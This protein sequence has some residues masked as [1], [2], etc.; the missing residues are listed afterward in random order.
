MLLDQRLRLVVERRFPRPRSLD[1]LA[2]SYQVGPPTEHGHAV[3]A[4]SA[5]CAHPLPNAEAILRAAAT[6]WAVYHAMCPGADRLISF[7]QLPKRVVTAYGP[8]GHGIDVQGAIALGYATRAGICMKTDAGRA[9]AAS[10]AEAC[11]ILSRDEHAAMSSHGMREESPSAETNAA[12]PRLTKR[13]CANGW[14][15]R[16]IVSGI[17]MADV[18]CHLS[19]TKGVC[20]LIRVTGGSSSVIPPACWPGVGWWRRRPPSGV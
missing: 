2:E 12:G 4:N 15:T 6:T 20:R 14:G 13:T 10:E 11:A 9:I 19:T 18:Y 8:L 16:L 7:H 5:R 1:D 17:L 3:P